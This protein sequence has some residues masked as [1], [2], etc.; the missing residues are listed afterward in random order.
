M[1]WFTYKDKYVYKM[2]TSTQR[3]DC[4]NGRTDPVICRGRFA[5]KDIKHKRLA[6]GNKDMEKK[7]SA[8]RRYRRSASYTTVLAS[9]HGGKNNQ[10]VALCA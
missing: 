9:G 7:P 3:A 4:Y 8:P 10:Q 6:N 5:P 1:E 2:M